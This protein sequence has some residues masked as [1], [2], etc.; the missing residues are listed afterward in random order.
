MAAVTPTDLARRRVVPRWKISAF[1][2]M[3]VSDRVAL[4]ALALVLL[5]AIAGPLLEPHNPRLAAGIPYQSPNGSF[6]FGTDDA[7]RDMLSRCLTGLQVTMLSGVVI[8]AVG[9]LIGGIV[10]LVAGAAGGWV[11]AVLMRATDLFLALPAPVLAIA[12]VAAFGPS[13]FHTL[14][15]ISIFWWPYYARLIRTEVKALAA[16]PHIEAVKLAGVGRSRRLI[17]HLLPGAIPTAIVAASL[18]VGSAIT[19]LASL[20]F[21]GLG[22]Q[23]PMPELGSMT[24]T[25]VADLQTAWWLAGIPALAVFAVVLVAN[26]AGDAVRDSV[27][28]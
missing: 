28:R 26:I 2:G 10:G 20:S 13:L 3:P 15:A 24:A 21:L 4:G 23:P 22:A 6:P 9:L 19:L 8:V 17:R 7:G 14:I 5:V 1:R 12:V 18:D 25:G 16:R 27:E 11:D